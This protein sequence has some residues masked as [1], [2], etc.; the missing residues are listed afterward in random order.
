MK[1]NGNSTSRETI[2]IL[3]PG[4]I[5]LAFIIAL[6]DGKCRQFKI[7]PRNIKGRSS[8]VACLLICRP[9]AHWFDYHLNLAPRSTLPESGT[10]KSFWEMKAPGW[11]WPHEPMSAGWTLPGIAILRPYG[12]TR[13]FDKSLRKKSSQNKS[14]QNKSAQNKFLQNKSLQNKLIAEQILAEKIRSEQL[15]A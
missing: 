10:K 12:H 7:M 1:F 3:D 4:Y 5:G 2:K 11:H 15:L 6:D 8:A 13:P 9:D 14:L